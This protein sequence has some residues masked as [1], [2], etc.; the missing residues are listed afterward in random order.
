MSIRK[1]PSNWYCPW[2]TAAGYWKSTGKDRSIRTSKSLAYRLLGWMKTRVFYKGHAPR[3]RRPSWIM[4]EYSAWNVAKTTSHH[5]QDKRNKEGK[6]K[7]RVHSDSKQQ[8]RERNGG[9]IL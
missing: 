6:E 3:G 7:G 4:H 8:Q 5:S 9:D 2:T 1:T